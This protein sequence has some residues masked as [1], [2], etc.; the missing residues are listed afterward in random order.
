[1]RETEAME[2][3]VLGELK[4][5]DEALAALS[6]REL[7]ELLVGFPPAAVAALKVRRRLVKNRGY[8]QNTRSKRVRTK[9]ELETIKSRASNE[10]RNIKKANRSLE[11]HLN[12]LRM[13]KQRLRKLLEEKKSKKQKRQ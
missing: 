11:T 12:E 6:I 5:S 8:A 2:A 3:E 7:N 9:R 4:L 13:K 1:M 10:I